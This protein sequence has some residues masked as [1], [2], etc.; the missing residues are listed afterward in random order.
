MEQAIEDKRCSD[1]DVSW[2]TREDE[3]TTLWG[4]LSNGKRF[5]KNSLISDETIFN[6]TS[7]DVWV[8]V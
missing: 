6:S 2:I 5:E 7:Q 1:N 3:R 4:I 8:Y